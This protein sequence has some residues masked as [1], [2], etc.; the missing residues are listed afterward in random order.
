[1][2]AA[3]LLDRLDR[4]RQ[5]GPGRWIGCCPSHED[6]SPSLSIRETSDGTILLHCFGGCSAADIVAAVGLQL[7]DLF[8]NKFSDHIPA[9]R[10][11]KHIHAASEAL[12]TIYYEVLIVAVAAENM[13]RGIPLDDEDRGRLWQAARRIRHTAEIAA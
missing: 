7:S 2:N 9:R 1:M 5:V 3:T 8:P 13:H 6:S 10:D 4:I 11:R 12:N